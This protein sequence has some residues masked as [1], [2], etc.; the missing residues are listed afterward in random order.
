VNTVPSA[1][2]LAPTF[3]KYMNREQYGDQPIFKRRFTHEPH[4]Q[5][6]Y[7]NYSSDLDFFWRY[8]MDHMFNRYLLWN[9]AGRSST[10]QDAGVNWRVLFGI[11]FFLA[12]FGIYYHFKK[13]W[14]MASV[15]LVMFIFLGY[16]TAFYQNQQQP[17]P[18]ERDYFYVGAFFVFSIW[19]ALGIRGILDL[20]KDSLK[21]RQGLLK[22]IYT[23]I[24]IFLI[25][26]IPPYPPHRQKTDHPCPYR[27]C[28]HCQPFQ[29]FGF[30]ASWLL[31]HVAWT[32][33]QSGTG[34]R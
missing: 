3:V 31:P 30:Q 8:Q 32:R 29:M 11:P 10:V 33:N 25:I 15:F 24:I 1:L 13:D 34:W 12:I 27:P 20:I 22:P 18:R 2:L 7:T 16:L 5:G 14:K 21:E 17:Q 4:Q 6:V 19:I 9:Y 23:G 28:H 26:V